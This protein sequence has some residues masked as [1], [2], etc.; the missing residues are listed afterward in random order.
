VA[1][2]L[3]DRK[4][5]SLDFQTPAVFLSPEDGTSLAVDPVGAAP[6]FQEV[7][8]AFLK[9]VR[10]GIRKE[11]GRHILAWTDEPMDGPLRRLIGGKS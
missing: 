8:E 2:H 3:A 10:G 5:L 6:E 11:G 7:V 4:E 1:V 9:E